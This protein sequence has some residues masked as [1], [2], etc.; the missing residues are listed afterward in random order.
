MGARGVEEGY[1]V[2]GDRGPTQLFQDRRQD[3]MV[4]R[5]AGYVVERYVYPV[6]GLHETRPEGRA[7]QRVPE[8]L[9][10]VGDARLV[11]GCDHVGDSIGQ[12]DLEPPRAVIDA[13]S[14]KPW[15]SRSSPPSLRRSLPSS[16]PPIPTKGKK[17]K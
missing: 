7:A 5:R 15:P 2:F 1:V 6:S 9:P 11:A 16:G 3:D 10:L 8:R 17:M 13:D 12:L 4:R 14:H